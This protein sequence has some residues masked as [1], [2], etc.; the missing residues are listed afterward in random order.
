MRRHPLRLAAV[1]AFFLNAASPPAHAWNAAGHRLTAAI[2][3]HELP[4]EARTRI[5]ELLAA[6]PD[7]DR[8]LAR[9]KNATPAY[10]AFLEASTWADEI[11]RDARFH[12]DG[13]DPTRTLAGFPDM[14]RHT[15]WH[16]VDQPLFAAP[17]VR[18]IGDGEL[19][20]Q[21]ARL[22][23][24]I[25]DTTQP[26]AARAYA[27]VWLIHLV[28][29]AHQP[30]HTVSRIDEEG[31]GDDGGNRLWVDNPFHP[32]LREMTLHA[33]WDDLPG[34]PWLRGERLERRARRLLESHPPGATT[35]ATGAKLS[36]WLSEGRSLAQMVVYADLDGDAPSISANYHERAQRTAD[37]RVV[38][39]GRRLARLL[40]E[41]LLS[42]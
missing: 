11:R 36:D 26:P 39:A 35:A 23:R 42:W 16:Y 8:W 41:L 33:Y 13:E 24:S 9:Q 5:G 34:P 30:L 25:A 3:W 7:H 19:H 22:R 6:H 2:A 10:A 1:F 31:R 28:G 15:R 38:T 20:L 17:I 21:L 37:E 27:L 14:A 4:N 18:N 12:D 32:R 40:T 29:D